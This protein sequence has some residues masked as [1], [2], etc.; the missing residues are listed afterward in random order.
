MFK[1]KMMINSDSYVPPYDPELDSLTFGDW[2]FS[3][4]NTVVKEEGSVLHLSVDGGKNYIKSIDYSSVLSNLR[5]C[6]VFENQRLMIGD[7]RRMFYSSDW[8]SINES[9]VYDINGDL[10][11]PV[12]NFDNFSTWTFDAVRQKIAGQ[13]VLMWNNYNNSEN[14]NGLVF[15]YAYNW[16]TENYGETIKCVFQYHI[17]IPQGQT[18]PLKARHGHG[19]FQHPTDGYFISTCGDEPTEVNSSWMKMEPDGNG[20]FINTVIGKGSVYKTNLIKYVGDSIYYSIDKGP[21]GVGRVKISEMSDVSKHEVLL[22]IPNDTC[23]ISMNAKGEI[24]TTHSLFDGNLPSNVIFYSNDF[25]ATW[26][27]ITIP[28]PEGSDGTNGVYLRASQPNSLGKVLMGSTANYNNGFQNN[29]I[30]PSMWIDNF[31]RANGFPNAFR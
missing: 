11:Q 31:I 8:I 16:L 18:E 13:D 2:I 29:K 23:G 9:Q 26:N 15:C 10:F 7:H 28:Y 5:V 1:K 12:L 22:S 24:V 20:G 14:E 6:Y 27:P 25:G 17:S 3:I 19:I 30:K 21:G 4:G